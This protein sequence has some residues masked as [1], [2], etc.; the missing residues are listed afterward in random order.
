MKDSPMEESTNSL[1]SSIFCN[2]FISYFMK[3]KEHNQLKFNISL[4]LKPTNQLIMYNL[5]F[6]AFMGQ[7]N[8]VFLL[9]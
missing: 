9:R 7:Y 8:L 5:I 2:M 4:F 1:H 3:Q 6:L